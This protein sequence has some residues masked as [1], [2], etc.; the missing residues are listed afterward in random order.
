MGAIIDLD[1]SMYYVF[2]KMSFRS[3]TRSKG[4]RTWE[5]ERTPTLERLQILF[6]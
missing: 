2:M 5:T 4:V 3:D 6:K 1:H